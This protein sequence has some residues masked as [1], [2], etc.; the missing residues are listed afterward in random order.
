MWLSKPVIS[1]F[2]LLTTAE[3]GYNFDSL[4]YNVNNDVTG[5][6]F[7]TYHEIRNAY[8]ILVKRSLAMRY[9]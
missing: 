5:M 3:I 1:V 9:I 8:N 4:S 2:E 6:A 7:S